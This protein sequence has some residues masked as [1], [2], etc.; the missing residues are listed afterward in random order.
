MT[1]HV[2]HLKVRFRIL[3]PS[4]LQCITNIC[5]FSDEYY[6]RE[7]ISLHPYQALLLLINLQIL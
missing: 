7:G 3:G 4:R 1:I 5:E 2:F 6:V